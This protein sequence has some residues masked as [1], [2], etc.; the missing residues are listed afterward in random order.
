MNSSILFPLPYTM[1]QRLHP[2]IHAPTS[3]SGLRRQLAVHAR[4]IDVGTQN[5]RLV[6]VQTRNP[7]TRRAGR[8]RGP[9][10]CDQS[11]RVGVQLVDGGDLS[12]CDGAVDAVGCTV[13]G[14]MYGVYIA[15]WSNTEMIPQPN[16]LSPLYNYDAMIYSGYPP[17]RPQH[18]KTP[19]RASVGFAGGVITGEEVED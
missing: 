15:L 13:L 6:I 19:L 7:I 18:P 12:D 17:S 16:G 5:A 11:G 3:C 9:Q 14:P 2:R 10:G 8:A 4:R 1:N